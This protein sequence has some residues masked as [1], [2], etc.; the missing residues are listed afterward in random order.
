MAIERIAAAREI[1]PWSPTHHNWIAP[2]TVHPA[3]TFNMLRMT[4][5]WIYSGLTFSHTRLS[6]SP[7]Y[8]ARR[9]TAPDIERSEPPASL[10]MISPTVC[11]VRMNMEPRNDLSS[12]HLLKH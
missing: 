2:P 5:P 9:H 3:E 6:V 8:I 12:I 11:G 7:S 4:P 10:Y 1:F